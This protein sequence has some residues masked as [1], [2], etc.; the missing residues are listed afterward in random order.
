MKKSL[1][2]DPKNGRYS[3][4]LGN[5]YLFHTSKRDSALSAFEKAER[6]GFDIPMV[7]HRKA[8]CL[9]HLSRYDEA[10][11]Q[12][13]I[14]IERNLKRLETANN[15][16][17]INRDIADS[18]DWLT[19]QYKALG[20]W[21]NFDIAAQNVGKYDPKNQ[22][23]L[24]LMNEALYVKAYVELGNGNLEQAENLLT[25]ADKRRAERI[26]EE[27]NPSYNSQILDIVRKRRKL[28]TI[29]PDV[30]HH[31]VLMLLEADLEY[32]S[33]GKQVRIQKKL[34]EHQK[35]Q[36]MVTVKAMKPVLEALSDGHMTITVDTV[37]IRKPLTKSS[38]SGFNVNGVPGYRYDRIEGI[39][40]VYEEI[41]NRY[42][43]FFYVSDAIQSEAHGG[44]H[45]IYYPTSAK[46]FP[47]GF[48]EISTNFAFD[49]W[50]HEFFHVIENMSGIQPT[51][52]QY[53]KFRQ[54]FP[55]W[56]GKSGDELSYFEYHFANT[57]PKVG[58][59]KLKF[60]RDPM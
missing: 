21:E 23:A 44:S 33:K 45:S 37:S 9:F 35:K 40:E 16:S 59:K 13:R 10:V 19:K 26:S 32:K 46:G 34:T 22:W 29:S 11:Q 54:N 52:G 48:V 2:L 51:H 7:F 18:Y 30:V 14:S 50:L 56:K 41:G 17:G 5:I 24:S 49:G 28:G 15:P 38:I 36:A 3:F 39:K 12:L 20:D 4:H 8:M 58:W 31:V 6:N 1:E 43:T 53:E 27:K 57:L 55:A 25:E 42:D 47:R 60:I